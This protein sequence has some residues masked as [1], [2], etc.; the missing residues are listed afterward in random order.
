MMMGLLGGSN[1]DPNFSSVKLL[2]GFEGADGST[3]APGM[4]DESSAAHGTAT[5]SGGVA[6]STTQFKFGASSASY[7]GATNTCSFANSS[8]WDFG[9]GLFTVECW[10]RPASVAAGTRAICGKWGNA[11]PNL[12][13]VFYQSAAG[14][15]FNVSTTGSDNLN[16]TGVGGTM[17]VNTWN[18]ACVDFDGTKT[19]IYLNGTMVASSVTLRTIATVSK[20]LEV[21]G[22]SD[23][24]GLFFNGN[25]DE[26]RITKGVARYASDGGYTVA[27]SAFPRS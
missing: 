1:H 24:L 6:I 17:T 4:T 25:I 5:V 8:D 20:P 10:I 16:D 3:G 22:N 9:A 13:W 14:L 27:T 2:M 26:L 21:G 18:A 19:R 12:E 7:T 23:Q 15:G 11:A